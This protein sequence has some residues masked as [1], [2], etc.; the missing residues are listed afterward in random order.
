[1]LIAADRGAG[2]SELVGEATC[3]SLDKALCGYPGSI[4]TCRVVGVLLPKAQNHG[5]SYISLLFNIINQ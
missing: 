4:L 3:P 2:T 1:M 5:S